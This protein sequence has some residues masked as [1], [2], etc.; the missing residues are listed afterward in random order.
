MTQTTTFLLIEDDPN[1]ALFVGMAF[2]EAP[3]HIRLRHVSSGIEGM[4]YLKGQGNY[5]DRQKYPLPD[6]ILLDLK[7]P[8]FSGFDF[9]KWLR[10]QSTYNYHL[11]PVIVM[12]SSSLQADI[13]RAYDLGVS[14][15][16]T[17][18]LDFEMFK[19]R[20]KLLGIFWAEYIETPEIHE[21]KPST[22]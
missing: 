8:G 19:E 3:S 1:D 11:L 13:T 7:M 10:S 14:A 18:P 22:L 9:L 20:L 6:V 17:K 5:A 16:M 15:Y 21:T 2:E 12:S 4:R